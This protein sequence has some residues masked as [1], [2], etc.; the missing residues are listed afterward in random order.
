[1]KTKILLL[2]SVIIILTGMVLSVLIMTKDIQFHLDPP[3]QA[4]IAF[5]APLYV[6]VFG[7]LL[8]L[9]GIVFILGYAFKRYGGEFE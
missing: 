9:T 7:F 5:A 8:S 1:M 3:A 6:V 4:L 2:T